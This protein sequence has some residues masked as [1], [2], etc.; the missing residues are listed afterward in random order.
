MLCSKPENILNIATIEQIF[1]AALY[2]R[3]INIK[4][5]MCYFYLL[6]IFENIGKIGKRLDPIILPLSASRLTREKV[7]LQSLMQKCMGCVTL[8]LVKFGRGKLLRQMIPFA[9]KN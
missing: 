1:V 3:T 7:K 4:F 2:S 9:V 8:V 6:L 5:T